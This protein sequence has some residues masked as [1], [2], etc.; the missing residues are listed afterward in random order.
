[1]TYLMLVPY[2]KG[3]CLTLESK[4]SNWDIHGWMYSDQ[5]WIALRLYMNTDQADDESNARE[6]VHDSPRLVSDLKA[7][8]ELTEYANPPMMLLQ[9]ININQALTHKGLQYRIGVLGH[10]LSQN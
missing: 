2:L 10:S 8:V 6:T 1:M 9:G 5:E 3:V 7:L 4:R